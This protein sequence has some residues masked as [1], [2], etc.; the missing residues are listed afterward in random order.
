MYTSIDFSI[1]A[2]RGSLVPQIK[3]GFSYIDLVSNLIMNL[4]LDYHYYYVQP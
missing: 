1:I 2:E 3:K 4:K